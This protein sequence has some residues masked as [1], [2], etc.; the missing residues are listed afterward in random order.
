MR[1]NILISGRKKYDKYEKYKSLFLIVHKFLCLSH[2]WRMISAMKILHLADEAKS[3]TVH[4]THC[5][6]KAIFKSK[7]IFMDKFGSYTH[8]TK[9]DP[10]CEISLAP[11]SS[12]TRIVRLGAIAF[13]RFLRYSK[14]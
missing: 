10:A 2:N 3:E 1:D 4:S 6:R 11:T 7:L 9:Q 5:S 13:I 12:P 8:F 14:S